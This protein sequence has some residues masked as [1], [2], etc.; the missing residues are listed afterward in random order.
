[1]GN[2]CVIVSKDTTKEN[3]N[4]KIG[5]YLHWY[6]DED[7]VKSLLKIAKERG[8]RNVEGDTS[9]FWARFCQVCADKITEDSKSSG[10]KIDYSA[11]IGIDIVSRLDCHNCDNGVYYIDGKFEIVK[12]TNGEELEK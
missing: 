4:K 5:I 7:T 3:A 2:R 6:G 12:H 11:G 1:M 10:N 9:Y 8:I